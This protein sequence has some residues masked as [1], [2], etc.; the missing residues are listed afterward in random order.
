MQEKG[1]RDN[2][3]GSEKLVLP[4]PTERSL[5]GSHKSTLKSNISQV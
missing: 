3:D 5:L 2:I 4:S 1:N